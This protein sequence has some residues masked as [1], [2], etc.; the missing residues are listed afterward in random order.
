MAKMIREGELAQTFCGTPEYIAPEVLD[1]KGYDKSADWWS[2]GILTYEMMYGLPPFYHESQKEMFKRIKDGEFRFSEK[3]KTSDEAKDFIC[4]LLNKD[5]KKR[6]GSSGEAG[7]VL[8]HPWFEGLD[9]EKMMR[10]EVLLVLCRSSRPSSPVWRARTGW[11]DSIR[12][13]PPRSP[14]LRTRATRAMRMLMSM[15]RRLK[16]SDLDQQPIAYALFIVLMSVLGRVGLI[17][18]YWGDGS[19][20]AMPNCPKSLANALKPKN[21][22]DYCYFIK[23]IFGNGII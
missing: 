21:V 3:V 2:L 11:R 15:R 10:K 16:I 8:A 14:L 18:Q 5:P 9:V 17:V 19:N 12:S 6:L 22:E 1:G 13:L 23:D 4:K 20:L 7:Q